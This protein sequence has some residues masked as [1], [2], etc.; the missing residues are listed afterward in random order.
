VTQVLIRWSELLMNWQPGKMRSQSFHSLVLG[1]KQLFKWRGMSVLL[2][3]RAQREA[4]GLSKRMSGCLGKS[5]PS[6][7]VRYCIWVEK[8]GAA[9]HQ[10]CNKQ[11]YTFFSSPSDEQAVLRRFPPLSQLSASNPLLLWRSSSHR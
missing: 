4:S 5:G 11:K 6:P 9:R 10:S 7:C 1:D 8:E 2:I 3:Q